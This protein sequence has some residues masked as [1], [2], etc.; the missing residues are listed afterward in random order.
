MDEMRQLQRI[1]TKLLPGSLIYMPNQDGGGNK[2]GRGR[3]TLACMH[4][5]ARSNVWSERRLCCLCCLL[6]LSLC[7]A[8]CTHALHTP[9]THTHTPSLCLSCHFL[10]PTRKHPQQV[11]ADDIKVYLA[12][13]LGEAPKP[14]WGLK[15]GWGQY[16]AGECLVLRY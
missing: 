3:Y 12:A 16:L 5:C 2:V 10:T 4:T 7:Y 11:Q 14:D 9:N 8:V 13:T 6:I 1:L 15:N